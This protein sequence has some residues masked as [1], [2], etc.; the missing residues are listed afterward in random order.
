MSPDF[1]TA[2]KTL[3]KCIQ[4]SSLEVLKN[5]SGSEN[6]VINEKVSQNVSDLH[7]YE[8]ISCILLISQ[9]FKIIFKTHYW[10]NDMLTLI[11]GLRPGL[12]E[13]EQEKKA[14]DFAKELCNIIAGKIK[15]QFI[16]LKCSIGQSLPVSLD[17]FN[18]LFFAT[19][20]KNIFT[21]SWVVTDQKINLCF[22]T[23]IEYYNSDIIQK[24]CN[25]LNINPVSAPEVE[26]F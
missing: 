5:E 16:P 24:I 8:D 12:Q 23:T 26:M 20:T 6:F 21:N 9:D 2:N 19:N 18:Q 4:N 1:E 25:D 17:G 10:L 22:S 7:Y 11:K 13:S 3:F 15:Y 14:K